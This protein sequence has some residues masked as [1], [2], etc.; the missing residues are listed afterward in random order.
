MLL[1]AVLESASKKTF[2]EL[3]AKEVAAPLG[4][5][6]TAMDYPDREIPRRSKFYVL[7]DKDKRVVAPF[8]DHSAKWASGGMVSTAED[9]DRVGNASFFSNFLASDVSKSIFTSGKTRDGKEV[10]FSRSIPR[11]NSLSRSLLTRA[12]TSSL[13][14]KRA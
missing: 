2:P 4:I 8:V 9:L 13:I 7:D 3:I 10:R 11:R 5:M 1:S 14:E 6:R 12:R